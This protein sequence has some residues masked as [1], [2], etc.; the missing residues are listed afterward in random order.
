MTFVDLWD[1]IV[2]I[3]KIKGKLYWQ[4]TNIELSKLRFFL[5]AL[6]IPSEAWAALNKQ[7]NDLKRKIREL[8]KIL[9]SRG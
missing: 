5:M 6:I 3:I 8:E 2:H 4:G 7:V 1:L 9:E